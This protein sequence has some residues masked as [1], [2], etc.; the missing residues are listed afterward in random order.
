MKRRADEKILD[1]VG[2]RDLTVGRIL[3]KK[4]FG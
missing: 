2:A 3:K 4:N 1:G